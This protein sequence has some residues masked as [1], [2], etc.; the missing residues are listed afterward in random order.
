MKTENSKVSFVKRFNLIPKIMCLLAAFVIWIYVM[1]TDSPDHEDVFADVPVSIT[2]LSELDEHSLSVFSG[3]DT[4]VDV[5]VKGQKSVIAKNSVDD[6]KITADVSEI[7]QAGSYTFDLDF[8][9][10]SGLTFSEASVTQ[11]KLFIDVK[12]SVNLDLQTKL[13][14]YQ[15]PADCE[16]GDLTCDTDT[17]TVTGAQSVLREISYAMV[18]VNMSDK[19][20]TE[21][22]TTD[23]NVILCDSAD[24]PIEN[25]YIKLSQNT[26]KVTVPVLTSRE[27]PLK[28]EGKYGFFKAGNAEITVE[29]KTMMVK[30]DRSVIESLDGIT[31]AAIN[32]KTVKEDTK[33]TVDIT[34]PEGVY[35]VSGEPATADVSIKLKNLLRRSM[36]VKTVN[37]KNADGIKYEIMNNGIAVDLIGEADAIKALTQD[38]VS[39]TVDLGSYDSSGAPGMIYPAAEVTFTKV[40]GTVYELGAYNV[41]MLIS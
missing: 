19:N 29:P 31:V 27:I 33:L 32:E 9:L 21:S 3:Q 36:T 39:L 23:G 30:G 8:D 5:T 18:D 1:E 28:A 25:K 22:F 11:L 38:N 37:V 10:P 4:V 16:L 6:I 7:T 35:P 2:G 13:S 17:V 26:A 20:L 41:Q 14:S 12:S 34:L 15:I 24:N 40:N